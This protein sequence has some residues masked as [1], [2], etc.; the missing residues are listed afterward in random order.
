MKKYTVNHL[1]STVLLGLMFTSC[2]EWTEVESLEIKQQDIREVNAQLYQDYLQ[3]LK[4]YKSSVH[5]E[6]IVSFENQQGAPTKSAERLTSLPDSIDIVCLNHPEL[7]TDDVKADMAALHEKGT[8]L[9]YLVDYG[10]METEWNLRVEQNSKLTEEDALSFISEQTNRLLGYCKQF[11]IDGIMVDYTGMSTVGMRTEALER[12]TNR[13]NMFINI[14]KEWKGANA[15]RLLAFYGNVQYLIPA[16]LS[17][18]EMTDYLIVKTAMSPNGDDMM[19]KMLAAI[20]AGKDAQTEYEGHSPVPADR[21]MAAIQLP[22]DGD[23]DKVI[24]YWN[25]LNDAG[26]KVLATYAAAQW[27]R[28]EIGGLHRK[29]LFL[30]NVNNDYYNDTYAAVR[31]MI[32]MMNPN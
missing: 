27:M 12:Y 19:V 8:R 26:Q 9:I 16:N 15:N 10:M 23:K 20:Q 32:H 22:K 14:I 31:Q 4:T 18:L 7:M 24:G 17:L 28:T 25:T 5:R 3:D 2:S 21:F 6:L 13:Q 1:L 29:G 30:L 11:D